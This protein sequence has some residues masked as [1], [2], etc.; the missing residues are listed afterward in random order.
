MKQITLE[1]IQSS[2]TNEIVGEIR[3]VEPGVFMW[4]D[5]EH[6]WEHGQEYR[7]LHIRSPKC[8]H[9]ILKPILSPEEYE[10]R[11]ALVEE[12]AARL[13]RSVEDRKAKAAAANRKECSA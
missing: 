13:I 6:T 7:V 5:K 4:E 11:R 9:T 2:I 1:E 10:R 8:I 3:E 12:A